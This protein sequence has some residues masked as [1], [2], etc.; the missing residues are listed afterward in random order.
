MKDKI[1]EQLKIGWQMQHLQF[2]YPSHA[3]PKMVN[4]HFFVFFLLLLLCCVHR[5]IGFAVIP[6]I[7][8]WNYFFLFDKKRRVY[9]DSYSPKV[10]EYFGTISASLL[11]GGIVILFITEWPVQILNEDTDL[12]M[13]KEEMNARANN[14]TNIDKK[15]K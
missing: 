14:I 4:R 6:C 8:S 12:K 1:I 15:E 5:Y 2:E 7:I 9:K 10:W 3:K 13:Q 11:I